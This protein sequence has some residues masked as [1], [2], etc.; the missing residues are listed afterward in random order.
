MW[1]VNFYAVVALM[2]LL[3]RRR[4]RRGPKRTVWTKQWVL[5]REEQGTVQNL[6]RELFL[7]EPSSSFSAVPRCVIKAGTSFHFEKSA[8][9]FSGVQGSLAMLAAIFESKLDATSFKAGLSLVV[10]IFSVECCR[11]FTTPSRE[12]AI[13]FDE[14]QQRVK[15]IK[16][17]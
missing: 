7:V 6:Q 8:S 17:V 5:R 11:A 14:P 10:W 2:A 1:A 15:N 4:N 3:L 13:T 12:E 16:H 9:S